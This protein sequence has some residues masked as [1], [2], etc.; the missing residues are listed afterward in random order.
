MHMSE[1]IKETASHASNRVSLLLHITVSNSQFQISTYDIISGIPNICPLYLSMTLIIPFSNSEMD[2]CSTNHTAVI[3]R[4]PVIKLVQSTGFTFSYIFLGKNKTKKEISQSY[5]TTIIDHGNNTQFFP[6][7][8]SFQDTD[9]LR[10]TWHSGGAILIRYLQLN[11]KQMKDNQML[12]YQQRQK[13]FHTQ[14]HSW[15]ET[16]QTAGNLLYLAF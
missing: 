13:L 7:T 1:V 6:W 8:H 5:R 11:F 4:N 12:T 15:C 2:I 10:Q 3:M 14:S 16:P 9:F